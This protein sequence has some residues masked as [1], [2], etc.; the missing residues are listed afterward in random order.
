MRLI[1][2]LGWTGKLGA[3]HSE[4]L[5]TITNTISLAPEKF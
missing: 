5:S 1:L 2:L 4:T 3:K